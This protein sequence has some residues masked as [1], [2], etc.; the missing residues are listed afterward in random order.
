MLLRTK[1]YVVIEKPPDVRMDG[2]HCPITVE[3]LSLRWLG[4]PVRWA[5]RLDYGTSGLLLGAL[6]KQA[7]RLSTRS[8][9]A[10]EAH[11]VYLGVAVGRV[12]RDAFEI[13]VP[14]ATTSDF[15]MRVAT[16]GKPARTRVRVLARCE[17]DG[18]AVTKLELRPST[19]RRH[20]LRVHLLSIG[21]PL[22]GDATYHGGALA[23]A[24]RMMLHAA[25][26]S[27]R[28]GD[29]SLIE[30]TT[31]DPFC[32]QGGRLAVRPVRVDQC[33][34]T[35]SHSSSSSVDEVAASSARSGLSAAR[36]ESSCV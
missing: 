28:L 10:G 24:P 22:V 7:A 23:D 19:G 27:V 36:A 1:D 30:A 17:Y 32:V 31:P 35:L 15:R 21:H 33:V 16:D 8:F 13:A 4:T 20:Q 9:E 25:E 12:A 11:K 3:T 34:A 29:G 18:V 2:L 5:H 14:I 26:L 6:T